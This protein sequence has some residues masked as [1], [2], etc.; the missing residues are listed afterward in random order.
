VRIS[1]ARP[2]GIEVGV[3]SV[4]ERVKAGPVRVDDAE[5]GNPVADDG[6]VLEAAKEDEVATGFRP[7]RLEVSMP[8]R[9]RRSFPLVQHGDMDFTVLVIGRAVTILARCR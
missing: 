1:V 2:R 4:G 9:D 6:I 7:R 5:L 3:R 8:G